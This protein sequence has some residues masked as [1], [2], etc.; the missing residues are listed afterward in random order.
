MNLNTSDLLRTQSDAAV[1]GIVPSPEGCS[2]IRLA[3]MG[4][5]GS[6]LAAAI[7]CAEVEQRCGEQ[8]W[9]M[10]SGIIAETLNMDRATAKRALRILREMELVRCTTKPSG[11]RAGLYRMDLTSH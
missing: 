3:A 8:P 4:L 1:G 5:S 11:C 9:P 10:S 6:V 7:L 2:R